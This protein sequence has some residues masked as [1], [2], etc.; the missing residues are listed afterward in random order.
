V[1]DLIADNNGPVRADR[2]LSALRTLLSWRARR[3][4]VAAGPWRP[5]II[6]AARSRILS[7]EELIAVRAAAEQDKGPFGASCSSCCSRNPALRRPAATQWCRMAAALDHSARRNKTGK[8]TRSC[9][10]GTEIVGNA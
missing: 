6:G 9:R 10:R 5:R 7:D 3:F 2:V 1:L 8:D 4:R